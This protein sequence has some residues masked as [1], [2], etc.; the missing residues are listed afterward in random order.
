MF[1]EGLPPRWKGERAGWVFCVCEASFWWGSAR[2][3][4]ERSPKEVGVVM[5]PV[6]FICAAQEGEGREDE[7]E[8]GWIRF[9]V[10]NISDD[11]VKETCRRL[12][13]CESLFGWRLR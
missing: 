11:D 9:S 8:N 13:E 1:R 5:L 10:A 3:V 7:D 6:A 2:D 4:S 12:K